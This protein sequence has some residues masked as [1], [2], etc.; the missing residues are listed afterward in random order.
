MQRYP[1][2]I[3]SK[4]SAVSGP[5]SHIPRLIGSP[6][7]Y[8]VGCALNVPNPVDIHPPMDS[9]KKDGIARRFTG[10][11]Q[12][13]RSVGMPFAVTNAANARAAAIAEARTISGSGG[14]FDD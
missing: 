7:T 4:T 13:W 12:S 3:A 11:F 14:A 6:I 10:Q 5:K 8:V 1:I 9:L 2:A